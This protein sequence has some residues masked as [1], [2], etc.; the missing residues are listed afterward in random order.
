MDG[1][2]Q[3]QKDDRDPRPAVFEDLDHDMHVWLAAGNLII[4]GLGANEHIRQGH[5]N[6][7]L[8]GAPTRHS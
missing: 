4:L 7:K 2:L 6:T 5:Q 8:Y 1:I 3:T